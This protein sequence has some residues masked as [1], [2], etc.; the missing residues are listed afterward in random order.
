MAQ[1]CDVA[2]FRLWF[3]T[4]G[5]KTA[6][7]QTFNLNRR[8]A[9]MFCLA[10]AIASGTVSADGQ[11][12]GTV[13][14]AAVASQLKAAKTIFIAPTTIRNSHLRRCPGEEGINGSAWDW[15][16]EDEAYLRQQVIETVEI[17]GLYAQ[18][19]SADADL[20]FEPSFTS[21]QVRLAVRSTSTQ[22]VLWVFSR[23]VKGGFLGLERLN[24]FANA[25]PALLDDVRQAAGQAASAIVPQSALPASQLSTPPKVFIS[26]V[27]AGDDSERFLL[28]GSPY[29]GGT[30]QAYNKFY[31]AV[32][33]SG[34]YQVVPAPA[35]AEL[36]FEMRYVDAFRIITA[37]SDQTHRLDYLHDAKRG[38]DSALFFYYPQV[39]LVIRNRGTGVVLGAMTEYVEGAFRAATADKNFAT[40]IHALLN[41]AAV[42]IGPLA[43]KP[44]LVQTVMALPRNV[45]DAPVPAQIGPA[46]KIFLAKPGEGR[47]YPSEAALDLYD[48]VQT[49]LQQWGRYELVTKAADADLVLEPSAVGG[50]LR[51]S[52]LDPGT[53]VVLWAIRWGSGDP[54][55]AGPKTKETVHSVAAQLM[56]TLRKLDARANGV[57]IPGPNVSKSESKASLVPKTAAVSPAV[58]E[59]LAAAKKVFVSDPSRDPSNRDQEA[60]ADVYKKVMAAITAWGKYDLVTIAA[61][62][63]LLFE[64]SIIEQDVQLAIV[65]PK[66]GGRVWTFAQHVDGGLLLSTRDKNMDHAIANLV[67]SVRK[68]AKDAGKSPAVAPSAPPSK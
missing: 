57:D 34:H 65:N 47:V 49:A 17:W 66:A 13:P 8:L 29:T 55:F 15:C 64:P 12:A 44:Q 16:F 22:N 32:Q 3:C 33:G 51:L 30:G 38:P 19:E 31:A 10:C 39:T 41:D 7:R 40:T 43:A 14:P 18:V 37:R 25:I 60:N 53:S 62:A 24:N 9:S 21:S 35:Q 58:S 42:A 68:A 59:L 36:I 20:I 50:M 1:I 46:R 61:S 2:I 63:D 5:P 28:G 6:Q 27:A 11:S 48:E 56:D 26:N 4:L 23:E 52:I 54:P 45:P 67:D